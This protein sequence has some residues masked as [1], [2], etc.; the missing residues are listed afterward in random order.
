MS[1]EK[2]TYKEVEPSAI[3]IDEHEKRRTTILDTI[4]SILEYYND[5]D[6]EHKASV[7]YGLTKASVDFD[8]TEYIISHLSLI[9]KSLIDHNDDNI[10]L[11]KKYFSSIYKQIEMLK[12]FDFNVAP[13]QILAH[14]IG[15]TL[16]SIKRQ[17][18]KK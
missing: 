5:N 13:N 16:S 11:I 3:R 15:Y 9:E 8:I 18:N 10:T 12:V 6:I 14:N 7:Q 1:D 2:L 4:D 17:Q